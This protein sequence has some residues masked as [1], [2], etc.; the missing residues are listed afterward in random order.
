MDINLKD[1]QF[2]IIGNQLKVIHLTDE[3]KVTT[4]ITIKSDLYIKEN[5]GLFEK[6]GNFFSW[7]VGGDFWD[8]KTVTIDNEQH[9]TMWV[10]TKSIQEVF[11]GIRGESPKIS[12]SQRPLPVNSAGTRRS[13]SAAQA[14]F[15]PAT[16]NQSVRAATPPS[17]FS[18]TKQ[19]IEGAPSV[20]ALRQMACQYLNLLAD[21]DALKLDKAFEKKL[22]SLSGNE[23]EIKLVRLLKEKYEN[24]PIPELKGL[25]ISYIKEISYS[26]IKTIIVLSNLLGLDPQ[27]DIK[28]YSSATNQFEGKLAREN[29]PNKYIALTQVELFKLLLPEKKPS[30]K[31]LREELI[32]LLKAKPTIEEKDLLKKLNQAGRESK[33][34]ETVYLR[35]LKTFYLGSKIPNLSFSRKDI[36]DAETFDSIIKLIR[37]VPGFPR[38]EDTWAPEFLRTRFEELMEGK[39]DAK[40]SIENFNKL[41]NK[42]ERIQGNEYEESSEG[43][44]EVDPKAAYLEFL[45]LPEDATTQQINSAYRT[46]SRKLHPDK[47]TGNP[48][49]EAQFKI[50]QEL[51]AKF[52]EL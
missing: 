9:T 39:P 23:Q 28:L 40:I 48:E 45:G 1:D 47:T 20:S 34:F 24:T 11:E 51:K 21:V 15:N 50:M 35:D 2:S 52:E 7:L 13:R 26:N 38:D 44:R 41:I 30:F 42:L 18:L 22:A 4:G 31:E 16:G 25:S 49:L 33:G 5:L 43:S 17:T 46:K 29:T 19:D 3:G 37:K 6:I 32:G 8:K 10:K 14:N 36:N 12:P 27:S